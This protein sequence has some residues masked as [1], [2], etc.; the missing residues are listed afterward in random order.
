MGGEAGALTR[1]PEDAV[2]SLRR[3]F[4]GE[5]AERLPLLR[6]LRDAAAPDRE[7]ARRAAHALASSAA[8]VGEADA[9]HAARALEVRLVEGAG[10]EDLRAAADE[11]VG[12]LE[13]WQP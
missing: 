11:V 4:A 7:A 2:A 9:S 1:L 8:V 12:L 13:G 6:D 5:L 3:A 10:L